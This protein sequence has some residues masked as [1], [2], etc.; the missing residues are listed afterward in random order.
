M[1]D[2][3][4]VEL[5]KDDVLTKPMQKPGFVAQVEGEL[6]VVLDTNLTEELIEEGYVREVISKI[7]TMRKDADFDVV[8]RIAVS[9][10]TGEKLAAI[11]SANKDELM[12][13]VLAVELTVC[14]AAEGTAVQEWNINGEKATIGVKVVG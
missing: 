10:A 8:D 6:T 3:T 9:V 11:I 7:Q 2:E 1:I 4:E 5:N 14:E 13:S 12:K